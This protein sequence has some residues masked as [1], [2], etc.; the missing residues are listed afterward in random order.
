VHK[1]FK[2]IN[3]FSFKRV[4]I[5]AQ[6]EVKTCFVNWGVPQKNFCSANSMFAKMSL[7]KQFSQMF[8]FLSKMDFSKSPKIVLLLR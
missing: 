8:A 2:T 5:L 7:P 6:F 1:S 4:K 3:V